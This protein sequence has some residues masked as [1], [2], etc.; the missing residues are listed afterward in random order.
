[1]PNYSANVENSNME[2]TNS[3]E[4]KR[5]EMLKRLDMRRKEHS[6]DSKLPEAKSVSDEKYTAITNDINAIQDEISKGDPCCSRSDLMARVKQIEINLCNYSS[7][8]TPYA[9]RS[10]QNRIQVI[11][12]KL[13][14][15]LLEDEVQRKHFGFR[16]AE[17]KINVKKE[18]NGKGTHLVEETVGSQ[19]ST[20]PEFN[21]S[22]GDLHGK[23]IIISRKEAEGKDLTFKNLSKCQISIPGVCSSIRMEGLV[24]CVVKTGPILTSVFIDNCLDCEFNIACQQL[25]VHNSKRVSFRL[26]TTCGAIIEKVREASFSAYDY[27][28]DGITADF[29]TSGFEPTNNNKWKEVQDFDF[30]FP[31]L[32]SPN[33]VIK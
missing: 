18:I 2:Q 30:P 15:E 28:Y 27:N 17:E 6:S 21:A 3:L 24:S 33:F 1:M 9:V 4:M 22:I 25:R 32:P 14:D 16:K 10:F 19:I 23:E 11:N 12:Q 26:H 5:L 13:V 20:I 29:G 31:G 7:Y 8:L